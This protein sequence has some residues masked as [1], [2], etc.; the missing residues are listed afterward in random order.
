MKPLRLDDFHLDNT[1]SPLDETFLHSVTAF[2]SLSRLTMVLSN[3]LDTLYTI[4]CPS[5]TMA[6]QDALKE[7]DKCQARLREW[8]AQEGAIMHRS[9][10][11]INGSQ[12]LHRLPLMPSFK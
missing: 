10:K 9:D 7:A 8:V 6:A 11:V 1:N 3:V 2:A 4:R 12:P 5:S